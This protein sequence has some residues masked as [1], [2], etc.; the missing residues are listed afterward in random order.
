MIQFLNRN[1]QNTIQ[2]A[3]S[4]KTLVYANEN[5]QLATKDHNGNINIVGISPLFRQGGALPK[6]S[7]TP[8]QGLIFYNTVTA[9][10]IHY[11]PFVVIGED[12]NNK[13][14]TLTDFTFVPMTAFAKIFINA[15]RNTTFNSDY[16]ISLMLQGVQDAANELY[17]ETAP[18][19]TYFVQADTNG[20]KNV[21]NLIQDLLKAYAASLDPYFIAPIPKTELTFWNYGQN[22]VPDIIGAS[23]VFAPGE[24]FESERRQKALAS[25]IMQYAYALEFAR[26][27]TDFNTAIPDTTA[28]IQSRDLGFINSLIQT[29]T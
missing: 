28:D 13:T 21:I 15:F 3:E 23:G 26:D 10:K 27:A 29:L 6:P 11:N 1:A 4:N 5:G 8:Y 7:L 22:P 2:V 16:L 25:Q 17:Q 9:A 14:H 12:I 24:Y 18:N 19:Q 20:S